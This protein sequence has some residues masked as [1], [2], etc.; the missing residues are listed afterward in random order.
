[1]GKPGKAQRYTRGLGKFNW[2][3]FYVTIIGLTKSKSS[4]AKVKTSERSFGSVYCQVSFVKYVG[5]WP[6][7]GPIM[8]I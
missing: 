4:E 1:M 8:Y 2:L 7:R 3:L 5:I 6:T